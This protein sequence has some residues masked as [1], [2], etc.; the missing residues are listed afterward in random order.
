MCV[1]LHNVC[2]KLH[3][4]CEITQCVQ[5]YTYSIGKNSSQLKNF[6]LTPWAAWATNSAV[7]VPGP[8]IHLKWF[9]LILWSWKAFIK[10]TPY[11]IYMFALICLVQTRIWNLL[12]KKE[13]RRFNLIKNSPTKYA[14]IHFYPILCRIQQGL[15]ECRN[16]NYI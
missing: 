16:F 13:T 11:S 7:L 6:T 14:Q 2:L 12:Q 4:V 3:T 9:D 5:N 15:Q 1:K 8:T 10:G